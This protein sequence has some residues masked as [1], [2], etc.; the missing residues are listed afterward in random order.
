MK[1]QPD[2][3]K[4]VVMA[5][6][7][8]ADD[9]EIEAGGTLEKCFRNGYEI[10]YVMSTNNMAG[11]VGTLDA[12]GQR[13]VNQ[14]EPTSAMM[15]RRKREVAEATAE[16]NT[17]AIHLD[18]PQRQYRDDNLQLVHLMYGT[19]VPPTTTSD[20][21]CIITAG[22]TAPAIERV[23]DLILKKNPECI[24]THTIASH[25]PEHFGTSLLVTNAYWRA[26]EQGF[27][28]GLLYWI[29]PET[30]YG[31]AFRRY[32]TFI[33]YSP[34]LDRKMQ[35]IGKH[36][37]Q[38]PH[39]H[40]PTFC[41]RIVGLEWGKVCGCVAAEAFI[42]CNRPVHAAEG[43]PPVHGTLTEELFQNSR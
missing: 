31:P 2:Q 28:G 37:C 29:E 6:G 21:P 41:H 30:K 15:A 20:T 9:I 36:R 4:P 7:A 16:W 17:E 3:Q 10:V 35:L 18:Y 38:M 13:G 43:A 27:R 32:D 24:L 39:A 25:N 8:H 22:E 12:T 14:E 42:W 11:S 5:I 26:W 23:A 33:D 40:L 1:T 19:P 34:L